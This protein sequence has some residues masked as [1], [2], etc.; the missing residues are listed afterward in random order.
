MTLQLA[1]GPPTAVS[2][3]VPVKSPLALVERTV[4][5]DGLSA[6][7]PGD[8]GGLGLRLGLGERLGEGDAFAE[9][10]TT[11]TCTAD[12]LAD[13]DGLFDALGDAEVVEIT[14]WTG[15]LLSTVIN[16]VAGDWL[17][18]AT[19]AALLGDMSFSAEY[20]PTP[21]RSSSAITAAASDLRR[22]APKGL[23]RWSSGIGKPSRANGSARWP[24]RLQYSEA[25]SIDPPTPAPDNAE[26]A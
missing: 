9:V 25:L 1:M 23:R 16:S 20:P 21:S 13:A 5:L 12:G 10:R 24:T 14:T 26:E 22:A 2:V 4:I 8:G 18:D 11:T 19:S 6:R 17:G 3:I 15:E 7:T